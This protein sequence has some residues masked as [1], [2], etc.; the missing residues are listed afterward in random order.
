M[1]DLEVVQR[2]VQ[3]N[4]SSAPGMHGVSQTPQHVPEEQPSAT[5]PQRS[6]ILLGPSPT[7]V[8]I[9]PAKAPLPPQTRDTSGPSNERPSHEGRQHEKRFPDEVRYV[10]GGAHV[11]RRKPPRG[12][13]G[14]D[15]R[16]PP[17]HPGTSGQARRRRRRLG[18]GAGWAG[19]W[20]LACSSSL[21]GVTRRG[22]G[23]R[24]RDTCEG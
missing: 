10:Q 6:G 13:R 7:S 11:A 3:N 22:E 5:R 1:G 18:G 2:I 16:A 12:A 20:R 19:S 8:P 4:A 9:E 24:R 23:G 14:G 21:V 17:I 15:T